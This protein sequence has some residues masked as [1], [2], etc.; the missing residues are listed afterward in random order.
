MGAAEITE[1]FVG[2][3]A[4]HQQISG[5]GLKCGLYTATIATQND[6]VIFGDFTEVK[7]VFAT[8]VATGVVNATTIDGTT[9]NKVVFTSATTGAMKAVVWGF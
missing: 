3:V 2:V 8:V 9:K 1:A 5:Q 4:P 7:D 6:W